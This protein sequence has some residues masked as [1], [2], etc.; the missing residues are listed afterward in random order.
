M[1]RPQVQLPVLHSHAVR[2][3]RKNCAGA[4]F[5]GDATIGIDADGYAVAASRL[6]RLIFACIKGVLG[7]AVPL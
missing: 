7:D 6:G 5:E 1:V 4:N 2:V 3:Q